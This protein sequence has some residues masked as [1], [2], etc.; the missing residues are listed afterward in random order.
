VL[1]SHL[2]RHLHP[3]ACHDEF[4]HTKYTHITFTLKKRSQIPIYYPDRLGFASLVPFHWEGRC[5]AHRHRHLA[6]SFVRKR[7]ATMMFDGLQSVQ[8]RKDDG[9]APL[10]TIHP[11]REDDVHGGGAR[12]R[13]RRRCRQWRFVSKASKNYSK[14]LY[15]MLLDDIRCLLS[16]SRGG[17]GVQ[18]EHLGKAARY[19]QGYNRTTTTTI[20]RTHKPNLRYFQTQNRVTVFIQDERKR[21]IDRRSRRSSSSSSK[22]S[23]SWLACICIYEFALRLGFNCQQARRVRP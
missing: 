15:R 20:H 11:W 22:S 10:I 6:A 4:S 16:S 13:R 14:F 1:T 18:E 2:Y 5:A 9:R 17:E 12:G 23:H 3:L 21:G 8:G 7:R 19:G